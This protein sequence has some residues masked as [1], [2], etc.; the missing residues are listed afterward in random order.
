MNAEK[1]FNISLIVGFLIWSVLSIF[2]YSTSNYKTYLHFQNYLSIFEFI[3]DVLIIY[4][5]WRICKKVTA[6][7]KIFFFY[8]FVSS[9]FLFLMDFAF[10]FVFYILRIT[11]PSVFYDSLYIIP[12][13]AFFVFQMMTWIVLVKK[14]FSFG[15]EGFSFLGLFLIFSF[16]YIIIFVNASA[17]ETHYSSIIG[18]EQIITSAI[19]VLIFDLAILALICSKNKGLSLLSSGVI[20]IVAANFWGQYLYQNKMLGSFDYSDAFWALGLLLMNYGLYHIYKQQNVNFKFWIASFRRIRSRVSLW[21]FSFSVLSFI[22]L[23]LLAYKFDLINHKTFLCLPFLVMLYSLIIVLVANHIGQKLEKPFKRLQAN[24]EML[25]NS[26]KNVDQAFFVEEFDFLQDF[27]NSSFRQLAK[28]DEENKDFADLAMQVAHDIRSPVTAVQ[29]LSNECIALPEDQRITLRNAAMRIQDIAN[30]LINKYRNP[31]TFTEEKESVLASAAILSVL[32]E[33]KIQYKAKE[34]VFTYDSSGIVNF[35]FVAINLIEFERMI[36]NLIDNSIE[37]MHDTGEICLSAKIRDNSLL[38]S[39]K[40]TGRGLPFSVA[41]Q[42]NDGGKVASHKHQGIGLGLTHARTLL[43]KYNGDFQVVSTGCDGTELLLAIPLA[44]QPSWIS[45]SITISPQSIVVILD[46]DAA[47]HGAWDSIFLSQK[48]KAPN[49]MIKHYH[50]AEDCIDYIKSLKA[51][52]KEKVLL[53]TDYEFIGENVNGLDV[54]AIANPTRQLLVTSH[55]ESTD[56]VKRSILL[57]T[58]ILPKTLVPYVSISFV[59]QEEEANQK[60][61]LPDLIIL[62]DNKELSGVVSYLYKL[63]GKKLLSCNSPYELFKNIR[64]MGCS[65]KICLDYNLGC[66]VNGLEVAEVLS[67][68][69]Y[70]NLYLSTGM[71]LN[72]DDVPSYITVLKEK[73]NMLNL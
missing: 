73:M 51:E 40:D 63:R 36:S 48:K 62:E 50:T 3:M 2:Y 20:F 5:S 13:I 53:L 16:I 60:E 7:T 47:I 21:I 59:E 32:T 67:E 58:K 17:W 57:N 64:G 11:K 66:P 39:I 72:A 31:S 46:D 38:L 22:S 33:K 18:I 4:L 43:Q 54:V 8:L 49:L 71:S 12:S 24:I 28:K 52:E 30:Y 44:E 61:D 37:S 26:K 10:F 9:I 27:I 34:M 69:G 41:K 29:V 23:L 35:A 15:K 19:E 14:S 42:L 55:Y 1:K 56:I 6:N 45:S 68:K 65:I 25:L 70:K